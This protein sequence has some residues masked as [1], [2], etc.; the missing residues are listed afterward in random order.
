MRINSVN[1]VNFG[2]KYNNAIQNSLINSAVN[3]ARHGELTEWRKVKSALDGIA[4]NCE[5]YIYFGNSNKEEPIKFYLDNNN[6][7]SEDDHLIIRNNTPLHNETNVKLKKGEILTIKKM[8]QLIS[9]LKN[10]EYINRRF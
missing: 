9:F 6:S 4:N 1:S 7:L 10:N 8:K 3:A 2:V 5:L